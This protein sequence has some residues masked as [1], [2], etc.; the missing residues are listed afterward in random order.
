MFSVADIPPAY[1]F[2]LTPQSERGYSL[3]SSS[4]C[5]LYVADPV[6]VMREVPTGCSFRE[7]LRTRRLLV[8]PVGLA[9]ELGGTLSVNALIDPHRMEHRT[10]F[11]GG[12]RRWRKVNDNDLTY[13]W[14][15][16][17]VL[18][19][20]EKK[21]Q[22]VELL[23]SL[24]VG[25][26]MLHACRKRFSSARGVDEFISIARSAAAEHF[27]GIAHPDAWKKLKS[28]RS[29]V[30][31][32]LPKLGFATNS[33]K[34]NTERS[35]NANKLW[36]ALVARALCSFPTECEPLD[37]L[38]PPSYGIVQRGRPWTD[39]LRTTLATDESTTIPAFH[40]GA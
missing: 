4:Y 22:E 25:H 24:A 34:R 5:A 20:E 3:S 19:R 38:L 39:R 36:T 7:R 8:L 31:R 6:V 27:P 30:S 18:F 33:T 14:K 12:C 16:L 32:D 29:Q 15:L 1:L 11:D 21:K 23:A 9:C 2:G 35:R 10:G 13:L 37:P 40:Q 28:K 26:L 17:H